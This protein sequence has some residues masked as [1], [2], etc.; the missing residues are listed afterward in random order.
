[1]A[2]EPEVNEWE[3]VADAW[4]ANRQRVF[5]TFRTASDWLV[6]AIGPQ[7]GQVVL[8]VAAGPGETGFLVADAVGPKG[9]VISSDLAPTMVA[10][11]RRGAKARG[12]ANVDC[13]MMDAQALDLDDDSVD[14]AISRL[15]LMLVPDP[16]AAFREL[17][18]V[19][20]S[21]GTVAYAV[22]GAPDQN[23]WM[24][25]MMGALMQNGHQPVT[26]NPFELG[27]PFGLSSP[28]LN[29][30][31]LRSAGFV[32]IQIEQIS[33]AMT[34]V[35][36]DDYWDAQSSLAGP[37]KAT[38]EQLTDDERAIVRATLA[39]MM[40]GFEAE[41]GFALPSQLVGVRAS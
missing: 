29:A 14:A 24:A 40:A 10:A 2:E 17:R 33:G 39:G 6:E 1:M 4:E 22:I 9:R 36:A 41:G 21:G 32:D 35:D 7:P 20:R 28:D 38:V 11:A 3:S 27:G 15:G 31:M 34:V 25:L 13:R 16:A 8:D 30:E 26:G 37:V 23:Q 5:D 18:R 12:L 19:V